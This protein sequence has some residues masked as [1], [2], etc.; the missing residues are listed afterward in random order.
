MSVARPWWAGFTIATFDEPREGRMGF[1]GGT[2]D[3]RGGCLADLLLHPG[4]AWVRRHVEMD[5]AE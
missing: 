1:G 4:K 5:D 3:A 2:A